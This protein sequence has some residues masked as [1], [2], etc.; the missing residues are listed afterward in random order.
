MD[1]EMDNLSLYETN[2]SL[3]DGSKILLRAIHPHDAQACLNFIHSIDG[4][5]KFLRLGHPKE[6]ATIENLRRFCTAD[7]TTAFALAAEIV[8]D[9]KEMVAIA[10]YYKL[11]GKNSA[12]LF[13][14]INEAYQSRGL[15]LVLMENLFKV[16]RS[17]SIST[18][19]TDVPLEHEPIHSLITNFSFHITKV[20]E[21]NISHIILPIVSSKKT[22]RKE[23]E[24][25]R[26][27]T[28]ESLK[29][30]LYPKSIAVIGASRYPG[31]IGYALVRSLIESG[32]VG[33]VYPVNPNI[34]VVSSIKTYPSVLAIPGEV[35][36]AVIAVPAQVVL[37]VAEE[38]GQKGV[39]GLIVISDGFKEA[40]PEGAVRERELREI[41]LGYGMR[42]VGPNCM[43]VINTDPAIN[44]NATF[45]PAV[46]QP[47][48]VSFLSQSGAMGEVILDYARSLNIGLST[49][50]SA[51]NR[52]DVSPNDLVQYWEHDPATKVILLYLESFGNPHNF[53]RITRRVSAKK[54]IVVVK[55]GSTSAG[56]RAA[57]SHTG[58][59]ATSET[60]TEAL[61]RQTGILRVN[62]IEE[63][64]DVASLLSNQPIPKGR[65]L[66]IVTNGGGPGILAAD[67]ASNHG[68]L[69]PE[70][71][72][73]TMKAIKTHLKRDI[74]INNPIDTTAQAAPAEFEGILQELA[75]DTGS[76]AVLFIFVPPSTINVKEV[77]N[78]L[79]RVAPLFR[80]H[81]KTLL[82]CFMGHKGLS[83]E[84]GTPG[85]YVPSYLFPESA[86]SALAKAVEYS[87]RLARPKS[88]PVKL[89][90]INREKA[91]GIISAVMKK[92]T[93]HQTWLTTEQISGLLDSY[94]IRF[95]ETKLAKTP[96]ETAVI[97]GKTGFPVVVKLASATI[98]H[99]TDVGG[100]KLNIKNEAEAKQAFEDIKA[101]L[102][103]LGKA[104]QMD[105]VVIQKMVPEGIETIVGVSN[106]SSFG[107]L[108]MFGMGGVNAELM[109]DV[110]FR[111]NPLTEHDARELIGSVK[112]SKLFDGY[113]GAPPSDTSALK[114]L[115]LR[116]SAMVEDNP[117]I[118]EL[119]FNPVKVLPAG[120]GYRVVDARIAVS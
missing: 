18:F 120:Q 79:R 35:E 78:G 15:G 48:N 86:I 6:A 43:G 119:D 16:A 65:R 40:G 85:K 69:L 109:N 80:H 12:E 71:L 8:H 106:D 26:L 24:E 64:F 96:E 56:S 90:D 87:E 42:I 84:V 89:H 4:Q 114:D 118:A 17:Q 58:A 3:E 113:R 25:E 103:E 39:K 28:I 62:G 88:T 68:L 92:S 20:S 37:K 19:E 74:R 100:V 115:L 108:I 111:L 50:V 27:A 76:D 30:I 33:A 49:F 34:E 47:G 66:V 1:T 110:A 14:L 73:E 102:T 36:M 91:S 21:K 72:P 116:I 93:Q 75:A 117:Q 54:P 55:S 51:G 31:T 29:A 60:V 107:H 105:G 99:K 23:E 52:A 53:V 46:N 57:S 70:I 67:A 13:I 112:M 77:E 82:V 2:V 63:L 44:M 97:A 61:F 95:A 38:C 41:A 10:R 81:Q 101:K 32:Y 94:G 104:D 22:I 45:S 59:L 9:G 98:T 5:S 83:A 7:N 11:P